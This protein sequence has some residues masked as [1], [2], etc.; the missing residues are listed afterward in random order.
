M[1]VICIQEGWTNPMA[2]F[3]KIGDILEVLEC[4][5]CPCGC[6][7]KMLSFKKL[8][9]WFFDSRHFCPIESAEIPETAFEEL[10]QKP[11]FV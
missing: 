4:R 11:A 5:K 10:I 3:P 1:K 7:N 9:V 2:Y 8:P 6:N